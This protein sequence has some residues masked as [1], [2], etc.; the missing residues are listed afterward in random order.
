[1]N[2]REFLKTVCLSASASFLSGCTGSFLSK[3]RRQPNVLVIITD[4]Q[5]YADVSAYAHAAPDVHTPH[6]DRL[7]KEG[8]LFT[9]AYVTA[10]ACSPSRAGWNTGRYQQRWGMWGWAQ[11]LPDDERLLSEYLKEAGYVTLLFMHLFVSVNDLPDPSQIRTNLGL[12]NRLGTLIARWL[13][14]I[15]DF[16]QG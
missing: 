1:M 10:P 8:V 16:S 2:R 3:G 14:I 12:F 6:I 15:P 5:G 4:D 7:A 11:P 13:T 9:Q